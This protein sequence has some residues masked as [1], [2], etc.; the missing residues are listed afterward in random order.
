MQL[1]DID[2]ELNRSGPSVAVLWPKPEALAFAIPGNEGPWFMSDCSSEILYTLKMIGAAVICTLK[3]LEKQSTLT[4]ASDIK[5]IALVLGHIRMIAQ[6]WPGGPGED[7]LS[8]VDAAIHK[9]V[10]HGID[11]KTAPYGVEQATDD[12][13][14]DEKDAKYDTGIKWTKFDWKKEVSRATIPWRPYR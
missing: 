1:V 8:W 2:K 9:A 14:A 7:E 13:E 3:T 6:G 11:F 4:A 5:N 12:I 10:K